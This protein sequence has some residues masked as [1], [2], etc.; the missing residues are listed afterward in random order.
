MQLVLLFFALVFHRE[1]RALCAP[2]SIRLWLWWH[3]RTMYGAKQARILTPLLAKAAGKPV[4]FTAQGLGIFARVCKDPQALGNVWLEGLL[5]AMLA[6]GTPPHTIS[7]PLWGPAATHVAT[8]YQTL[9]GQRPWR[10]APG[11]FA[12]AYGPEA[13]VTLPWD[14]V[15][16]IGN[17]WWCGMWGTSGDPAA[18]CNTDISATA[19][20]D[21]APF[22]HVKY[23]PP[24]LGGSAT[25][26]LQK[27]DGGTAVPVSHTDMQTDPEDALHRYLLHTLFD[28]TDLKC[29]RNFCQLTLDSGSPMPPVWTIKWGAESGVT[30]TSHTPEAETANL[31]RNT[32]F[33]E[34]VTLDENYEAAL[35]LW[36]KRPPTVMGVG[37]HHDGLKRLVLWHEESGP[38]LMLVPLEDWD[39]FALQYEMPLLAEEN[40]VL[41]ECSYLQHDVTFHSAGN[42]WTDTGQHNWDDDTTAHLAAVPGIAMEGYTALVKTLLE[43]DLRTFRRA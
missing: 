35:A 14:P 15:A 23:A 3:P 39:E 7:L 18:A 4:L 43:P 24:Y 13:V 21:D 38:K 12:T 8:T 41:S 31:P 9:T 25:Y 19:Q 26:Q 37:N 5:R 10:K 1:I 34:L 17:E 36:P 2:L 32:A 29:H 27:W 40:E 42:L 33:G 22:L 6:T 28:R 16:Q 20:V 11:D 30:V